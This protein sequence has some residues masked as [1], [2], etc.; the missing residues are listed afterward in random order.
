MNEK[1]KALIQDSLILVLLPNYGYHRFFNRLLRNLSKP[2]PANHYLK[3]TLGENDI[4]SH[5]NF[6]Y[7]NSNIG[8]FLLLN[9]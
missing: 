2:L 1:C 8:V 7:C 3:A 6:Q 9:Y 5:K 4:G